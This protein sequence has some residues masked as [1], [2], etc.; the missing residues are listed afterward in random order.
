MSVFD[1]TG[2]E[3]VPPGRVNASA[4][5]ATGTPAEPTAG[6]PTSGVARTSVFTV[7]GMTCAS[8][9]EAIEST[10][11]QVDGVESIRV[12]LITSK[13]T[14]THHADKVLPPSHSS[15]SGVPDQHQP[16]RP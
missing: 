16:S 3:A 15:P 10:I 14:V 12:A 8:C 4:P 9:V 7:Q 2:V 1:P 6:G 5:V 11:A 13:A